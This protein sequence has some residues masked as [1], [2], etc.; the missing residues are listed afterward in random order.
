[1]IYVVRMDSPHI[2]NKIFSGKNKDIT[3][4]KCQKCW[5]LLGNAGTSME[6]LGNVGNIMEVAE[7]YGTWTLE[8][9]K[10]VGAKGKWRYEPRTNTSFGFEEEKV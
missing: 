6:M 8:V 1:M 3:L 5:E 9:G 10:E 7:T 4:G 2:K